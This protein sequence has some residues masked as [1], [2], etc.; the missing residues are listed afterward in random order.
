MQAPSIAMPP[1]P[2]AAISCN[3]LVMAQLGI[4]AEA[5][6][7]VIA[8]DARIDRLTTPTNIALLQLELV[9]VAGSLDMLDTAVLRSG[10]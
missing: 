3:I 9:Q 6:A 7:V 8:F 4:P 1:L 5:I 2:G 10:E